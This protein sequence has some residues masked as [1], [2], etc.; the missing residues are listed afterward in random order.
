MLKALLLSL[1]NLALAAMAMAQNL[2]PN[3]SFEDTVNCDMPVQ[4]NLLRAEHWYNPNTATPDLYDCDL[5][6]VCGSPM[7]LPVSQG[8]MLSE[9]GLRHTGAYFWYGPGSSNARDYQMTKLL[10]PMQAGAAYEVS[11]WYARRR[12]FQRAV[13]HI[14][15]WFGHDSLAQSTNSWLVVSPQVRLRDPGSEFLAEEENWTQLTDTLV[16]NGGEE[17]MV[18]GNFDA[19]NAVNGMVVE[20]NG[21]YPPCY[22]FID[23]VSVRL[24]SELSVAEV[25]PLGWWNGSGIG[26]RWGLFSGSM[27][28]SLWDTMGRL[29]VRSRIMMLN[30]QADLLL[31]RLMDGVYVLGFESADRWS[32]M[33]FVKGEGGL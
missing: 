32:T 8:F 20:P 15:V 4:C 5:D 3:P 19:A 26:M 23:N 24:L 7:D 11:A 25:L 17:W 28:V 12:S 16:A 1:M 31:P 18:I 27:V 21:I 10:E 22:Y 2:V 14:G 6:R 9:D 33:V 13:D 30:G 29:L